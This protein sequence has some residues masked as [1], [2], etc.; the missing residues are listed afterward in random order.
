MGWHIHNNMRFADSDAYGVCTD[1]PE[2]PYEQID[3]SLSRKDEQEIAELFD[4][5]IK[6]TAREF[7]NVSGWDEEHWDGWKEKVSEII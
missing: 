1:N 5:F 7:F 3:N 2:T 4:Q 6:D